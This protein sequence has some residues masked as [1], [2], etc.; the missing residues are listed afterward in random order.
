[1]LI[2]D[3]LERASA[4]LVV[5][6]TMNGA[7]LPKHDDDDEVQLGLPGLLLVEALA[8]PSARRTVADVATQAGVEES[9]VAEL[10]Q[11]LR[12]RHL[13]VRGEPDG[14]S[15]TVD[16]DGDAVVRR[17]SK[18][19]ADQLLV[20]PTP[21]LLRCV[22]GRFR[23]V[24]HDGKIG[25]RLTAIE[26]SAAA[27]FVLPTSTSDALLAHHVEAGDAAL[28]ADA[29]AD[30]VQRT[31][32][33]KLLIDFDPDHAEE[34]R[35]ARET[36]LLRDAIRRKAHVNQEFD[37]L[38]KEADE[39]GGPPGRV[40]VIGAHTNWT[41]APAGLG[42]VIA[43]ARDYQDGRLR[44]SFDFRPRLAWDAERLGA[45]AVQASVFLFSNYVW[46]SEE[47]L[48]LSSLVKRTNPGS[49]TIHGGPDTPKYRG[50]V[51]QYFA[52]HPHVD[53]AVHGEGE[54]TL[55]ELLLALAGRISDEPADLSVL[56]D[57]PGLSYR[58][59]D[60]VVTTDK[61]DRIADLDSIPS[62]ILTGIFDGFIPAGP[63]GGV[64]L[65]TN[66]G[67]P[68]GCTFCD[69]GSATL[70]RV[71]KFDMERI[72][73]ELEWCA[74]SQI[75][76]VGIADANFGIFERDVE[77]S[78]KIAELKSQ[79]GFPQSIGNNYAKNTVKHLEKIVEIFTDA[80][81]VAEG[82]MSMQTFDPET[83]TILRRKNIKVEKYD[84]LSAQFRRNR[85]PM[86]VDLMLGLPGS[87]P[88]SFRNDLQ[89]CID[90]DVRAIIHPTMLL[91]NSP[92][93]EPEYREENGIIAKPG[94]YVMQTAS[95]TEDEWHHMHSLGKGFW[96][97]ENFGIL[98]QLATHVRLESGMRE[99]DFYERLV[100]DARND[101]EQWP[102]TSVIIHVLPNTMVPPESW[103]FFLDEVHRHVV[104]IEGIADDSA[105]DTVLRVQHS[106][107]PTRHRTFPLTLELDHDYVA[108]RDSVLDA[109]E[110]GHLGDWPDLVRP[111]REQ[112][113]GVMTVDDPNEICSTALNGSLASISFESSWDFDSPVSRARQRSV[114]AEDEVDEQTTF[115]PDPTRSLV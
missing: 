10:L 24:D 105:L 21:L 82:K 77:I 19:R 39:A 42:M 44:E 37:R 32:S 29:F 20:A 99:V 26:L 100:V 52:D 57:V 104:D 46:S 109:R 56:A 114:H 47:N 36:D 68:Y 89:A 66:R 34:D 17:P 16:D 96:L 69:W 12:R 84:E 38:E 33:S 81:I 78:E 1:V 83:L 18:P 8:T 75:H 90:R 53:I 65:E 62:P 71:R 41:S 4:A 9:R 43:H 103:K 28:D 106:L 27:R 6:L 85:L 76:I 113:P 55:A 35:Q 40:P 54:E 92:M 50:D 110:S 101:P 79:Y 61:R 72:F 107:L 59:G 31:L 86:S 91:P 58:R 7:V 93:N 14:A 11:E 60:E 102:L 22:D 95:Y 64:A 111:L 80:G 25:A 88:E 23:V 30:V 15:T 87:T 70:S 98:R 97:F 74:K 112:P 5:A 3:D 49:V 73:A 115:L 45:A 13:T 67:C 94:E 2:D 63:I 51:V 48:E 108:W